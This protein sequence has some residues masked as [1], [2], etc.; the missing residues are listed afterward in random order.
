MKPGETLIIEYKKDQPR[1]WVKLENSPNTLNTFL[2][3]LGCPKDF[4]TFDIFGFDDD[5]LDMVPKP[6]LG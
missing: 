2:S 6:C 3:L 1:D 5:L 4:Q